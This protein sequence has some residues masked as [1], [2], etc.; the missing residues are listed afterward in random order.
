MKSI[1]YT[2][3]GGPEVI[4]LSEVEKPQPKENE[5]LIRV[6][7]TTVNPFEIKI[8]SGSMKQQIPVHFPFIPGGD[9][10]G[11]VEAIGDQVT[12]INVGD[13][14]F[15][16]T[17]GD[18][19]AEYIAIDAAKVTTIPN[20]VTMNEAAALAVPLV[21]A[22][23]FLVEQGKVQQGQ[24]VLIQ[25]AGGAV[26][27]VMVQMAKAL[28]AKVTGTASGDGVAL[29]RALGAEEV[30]DYKTQDFTKLVKDV[31]LVID[32]VGGETQIKSFEVIKKNGLLLSAVMPPS[33][34]LAEK[35]GISAG[36][37]SSAPAFEKL[38]YGKQMVEE[39]KIKPEIAKVLPLDK[40]AE[41]QELVS[42]GGLNGKVVLVVEYSTFK[43]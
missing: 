18:T 37:T 26:G 38:D 5:V 6:A 17:F 14:V 10:A 35:Y 33:P 28:G 15:A 9:V 20:N 36:F 19:Y 31:D 29:V 13:K 27:A 7:A 11:T 42:K 34:E 23:T 12:R 21:T 39:G 25:G 1:Q 43:K 32:L 8:R 3:Y 30:I 40:A 16:T 2:K 24:T 4:T 41:A 22:Y